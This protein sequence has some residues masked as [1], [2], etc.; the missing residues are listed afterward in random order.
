MKSILSTKPVFLVLMICCLSCKKFVEI[1]PPSDQIINEKVYSNDQ[2]ATSAIRGIYVN[3]MTS[4]GFA[5]GNVY[6]V[7]M[8]AGRSSDEFTNYNIDNTYR[9]F[10]TNNISPDNNGLRTGLWQEPYKNIY[11]ANLVLENLE[12]SN[13]V[14]ATVKQQ[15]QG[16][17]KFIRAFCYFYLT[18]LFGSV[19]LILSTDYKVNAVA[20]ASTSEQIYIQMIKDLT[21]AKAQLSD[22]YPSIERVRANR[23]AAAALL[24]R[25]YLYHRQWANAETEATGIIAKN[26]QYNL[27]E[28]LS[29]VFLKNNKEAILQF[30]VPTINDVNTYE[31]QLFILDTPPGAQTQVVLNDNLVQSFEPNDRRLANWVG[32][33]VTENASW[34][35]AAKYKVK[36]GAT[37][38]SEYSM[39]L[40]LGEQYLIRA[41][42]RTMQDN[43]QGAR[44]DLNKIR[45]R[46]GL[47]NLSY[48][49]Q[50]ELLLAIEKERK[51]ELFA[52]WGH[53]W[54]DLKRT[55]RAS[56]V[57][58]PLKAPN[59]QNT[60]MLYPIPQS[61]IT[62]NKNLVQNNGYQ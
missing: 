15:L 43:F 49:T 54:L 3:M 23:W 2:V 51:V 17:A 24:A 46:A 18:N 21:E 22:A 11:A 27:E 1:N 58:G 6:S 42:A 7:T 45:N 56:V 62:N 28:N 48:N 9:Q 25:V 37:P 20:A 52:E 31:G 41:E 61:E 38:S 35:Y 32:T 5:S 53:R 55:G 60:D 34:H 50:A 12:K 26:D 16:E 39:V 10:W 44:D 36:A 29:Q 13:G 14:T 19:P 30:F 4:G 8:L 47:D 40:R 33:Y 59:W 57:L